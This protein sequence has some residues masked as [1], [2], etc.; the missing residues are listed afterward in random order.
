MKSEK[1]KKRVLGIFG[2]FGILGF[3]TLITHDVHPDSH[4]L[5]G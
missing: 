5:L 4:L 1:P 2:F 3:T